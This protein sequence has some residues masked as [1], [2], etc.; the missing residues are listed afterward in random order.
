MKAMCK[1]CEDRGKTWQGSNPKCAFKQGTFS[2]DNWNCATMNK[3]RDI[4]EDHM[5]G[6]EDQNAALLSGVES[7]HIVLTWYKNRGR[8]EGAYMFY[9]GKP[10]KLT[11]KEA[12]K[13]LIKEL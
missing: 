6:N 4:C 12:E 1:L 8:T 13:L 10:K 9:D 7:D 3:L 11:I 2:T 5:V